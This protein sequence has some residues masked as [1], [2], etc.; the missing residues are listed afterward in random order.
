MNNDTLNA[1]S[2]LGPSVVDGGGNEEVAD[3]GVGGD[4]ESV[5]DGT[6][7]SRIANTAKP[8]TAIARPTTATSKLP[9]DLR[10]VFDTREFIG[11]GAMS[12]TDATTT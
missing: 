5:A 6:P 2:A 9:R 8:P 3:D 7:P 1:G 11:G 4:A 10:D 12:A